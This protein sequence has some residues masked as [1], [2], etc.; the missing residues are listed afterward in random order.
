MEKKTLGSFLSILRK[1]KGM[2]QKEL[3]ELLNVSDKAVSRWERDESMPDILLIPVLADIFEVSCD[4]LLKGERTVKEIYQETQEKRSQRT[5]ALIKKSKS[6]FQA[7]SMISIGVALI[8]FIIAIVLN[9]SLHKAT[10]GF[11]CVL[12]GILAGGMSQAAF[13]IYFN[14]DVDTEGLEGQEFTDYKKYIRDHSLHISCFL[15]TLLS[16]CLPL[17]FLGQMSYADY[18]AEINKQMAPI[19]FEPVDTAVN[20]VFPAGKIAVGLQPKTWLIYGGIGAIVGAV[21][22]FII[23]FA[24][25]LQDVKK[26]RFDVSEHHIQKL[27]Q[28]LWGLLKYFL[29]LIALLGIT[30]GCSKL[31]YA[32]MPEILQKGKEFDNFEDFKEYM[33]TIP[34]DMAP[35]EIGIRRK[36]DNYKGIVYGDNGEILCEYRRFNDSVVD[37][38]FGKQNK[39][40]I[41]VYSENDQTIAEEKTEDLMW[42]WNAMLFIEC[43]VVVMIY[44]NKFSKKNNEKM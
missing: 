20:A 31:F 15:G 13:Y 10:L 4:E 38:Q 3:A 40:P 28:N 16:I 5:I 34:E 7:F 36:F 41:T 30:F 17:L 19:G 21:V 37:I 11:Y 44:I 25:K 23:N 8:G 9:F 32:K 33:E 27:K 43:I 29:I 14:S 39:L 6:K 24:I 35:G 22:S 1:A 42:L 26:G 2:T 12:I 18:I